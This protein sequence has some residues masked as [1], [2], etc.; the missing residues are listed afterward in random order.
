MTDEEIKARKE[1][2]KQIH[3]L[4]DDFKNQMMDDFI[5][6]LFDT[7]CVDLKDKHFKTAKIMTC[8]LAK[9]LHDDYYSLHVENDIQNL[10]DL[11]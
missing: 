11:I 6:D 10:Y 8:V 2:R 4:F 9:L 3:S 5:N 1:I 7:G